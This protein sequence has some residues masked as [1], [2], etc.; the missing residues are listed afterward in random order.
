MQEGTAVISGSGTDRPTGMIN[1][2]PTATD[3]FGSPLRAAAVYQFVASSAS[4]D[5]ILPDAM[6]DLVYKVNSAYR[7]NATWVMNS[8][9]AGA[10]RKLKDDQ[11]QYLWAPGLAAGQPD[12][13]LGYPVATWEQMQDIGANTHPVAFGDFRRGYILAQRSQ[14]RITIDS[15][16][17]TPGR[18][19][20]FVRRREG[21]H[22]LD[23]NAVKFLKT[24]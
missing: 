3:D 4:P 13:L 22:V 17:T 12:M 2:V 1:T 18:I 16:I 19:K 15:N 14:I 9:T 7:S 20:Y 11:N 24:T 6:I 23:N 10:V 21:G 5:A 8:A